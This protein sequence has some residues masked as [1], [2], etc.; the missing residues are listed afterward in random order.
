MRSKKL[1]SSIAV[2]G[3]AAAVIASMKN[4]KPASQSVSNVFVSNTI[5]PNKSDE[6]YIVLP[7]FTGDCT[8]QL[9]SYIERARVEGKILL[10]P[11][12][13][14]S[15]IISDELQV[16]CNIQSNGAKISGSVKDRCVFVIQN[17]EH[18]SVSGL[19]IQVN[20]STS[21]NDVVWGKH[22]GIK[23]EN[24][25][26]IKLENLR[27]SKYWGAAVSLNNCF[28]CSITNVTCFDSISTNELWPT[29]T[30]HGDTDISVISDTKGGNN[31]VHD[32]KCI[33]HKSSIGI[34]LNAHGKDSNNTLSNNFC[35]GLL[36]NL[37]S[38]TLPDL[39]KRHGIQVGYFDSDN[40][41]F[42]RVVNNYCFNTGTTG[43]SGAARGTK[44][45]VHFLYNV[46]EKNGIGSVDG[47]I[48]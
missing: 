42:N 8:T 41:T 17:Q 2:I 31:I 1:V 38:A 7:K 26:N 30:E 28:Y 43:I 27:V 34:W 15:Y 4:R 9:K 3:G 22:C 20:A 14:D 45:V 11:K 39:K 5:D 33:S 44:Q 12:K 16:S 48:L 6:F 29:S 24:S 18:L 36:P 23:V 37:E 32:C 10:I 46:C 40:R 35:A 13:S 25:K 21:A 47:T 19:E